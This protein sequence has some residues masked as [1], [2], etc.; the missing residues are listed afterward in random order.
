MEKTRWHLCLRSITSS[1]ACPRMFRT[2]SRDVPLAKLPRA[3]HCLRGFT[4]PCLY[5]KAPRLMWAWILSWVFHELKRGKNSV[6]MV[7]DWFSKMA[8]FIAYNKTNDAVQVAELYFNKVK[9]LYPNQVHLILV[10]LGWRSSSVLSSKLV[11]I[12]YLGASNLF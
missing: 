9:R 12:A 3:T 4:L 5:L 7:V 6:C 2:S 10:S 1:E 11:Q 8:H